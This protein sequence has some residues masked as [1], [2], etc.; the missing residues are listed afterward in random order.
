MRTTG[1]YRRSIVADEEVAAFIPNPLPPTKP[2]L[3]MDEE[4]LGL[5]QRAEH[6]LSRLAL[7]GE[8]IPSLEWFI[9]GFVRK[10]AVVSSQIEGTQATLV[11]LLQ[12]EAD[13]MGSTRSGDVRE[14]CNLP[15]SSLICAGR[16]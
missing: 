5:L 2:E 10:E 12:F 15:G 14:V 16:T 6:A 11:D 3:N 1:T 7:A 4:M 9:Y 8:M 13:A